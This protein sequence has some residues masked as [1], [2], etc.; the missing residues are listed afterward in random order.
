MTSTQTLGRDELKAGLRRGRM[1]FFGAFVFSIFVNLLMLTGPL[2]ML[3]VYD[4]VLASRSVET[5]VALSILV[6][7]LFALMA[8]L[9]FAR[10]RVMARVGA[11]FQTALDGRVF[12][13]T[14]RRSIDPQDQAKSRAALRDLDAVQ[15]FFVSPVLLALMDI[16]WTP[17]FIAAIFLFHPMLGWLAVTGGVILFV[18]ALLNQVM[19]V[20]RVRQSQMA[21]QGAHSFADQAR[22][23]GEVV[24]AQGMR[25]EMRERWIQR[26]NDGLEKSIGA[27]D[28]TGSFASLTKSFRMFL[29]SAMLGLGAFYVL[30]GEMTPGSMIAGTILLGRALAPIEQAVGQWPA[31]QRARSG[32]AALSTYLA[33]VPP[34]DERTELPVPEAR[35]SVAGVSVIPPGSRAP[36]LRNITFKLEPGQALGV[37]GRSGSGKS[38][39]ARTLLGYWA[40][41][42]GEVRLGGATLNQYDPDRLGQHIGYLPQSVTLF[43]G[44]ITENIARMARN[45]D[46]KA[47]VEA[48]KRS[49]AHDMITELPDGYDTYLNGNENQLSGGQRQRIALARALYGN[50]VLLILDE[51]NSALDSG[52]S[53]A[54]NL[55]VKD[56]KA[57]G[58]AVIIMTHRPIAI[59]EC[60]TLMVIEKGAIA[61]FG[62]RDE[63][64]NKMLKNAGNVRQ[65]FK[66]RKA[67]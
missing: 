67:I 24:L 54:L 9:D 44:T 5:L 18:L 34:A 11:R 17:I 8:V 12:E 64:M 6:T 51:P 22:S 53:D 10:G 39:L 43:S 25:A 46:S 4:R 28:W 14:L 29:Q 32:W 45:P 38:T 47:V 65:T 52:G 66:S 61:S 48:A 21:Q 62:P 42:A 19:T 1:L 31:L 27:N 3:Q 56:F 20:R 26:R 41:A 36:T 63:V 13:A 15:S 49:N 55:A 16:P 37:I 7:G 57:A 60:D 2:Y 58:N 30:Q 50:P 33:Q 35:L 40:P 23:G 59:A